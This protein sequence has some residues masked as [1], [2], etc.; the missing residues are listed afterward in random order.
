MIQTLRER[1]FTLIELLVVIAI[2]GILAATVLAA[3][4]TARS[5]GNDASA[6]SS[7]NSFKAQAELIYTTANSYA[8]VC[9]NA[10]TTAL[11]S[12]ITNN[13]ADTDMS[14]DATQTAGNTVCNDDVNG[15]AL[16][17]ALN[18]TA[19]GNFFCVDSSGNSTTTNALLSPGTD[20]SC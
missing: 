2:I 19:G 20:I 18:N 4:G 6:K 7:A 13:D 15:Y 3:L 5:S 16:S 10:S 9:S 11:R 1:G 12:A 8:T 17:V 14:N